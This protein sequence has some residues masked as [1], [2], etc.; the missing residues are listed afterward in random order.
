MC[1]KNQGDLGREPGE[2]GREVQCLSKS[3][4]RVKA[5][6]T[7]LT[8]EMLDAVTRPVPWPKAGTWLLIHK[9]T[10]PPGAAL[11]QRLET[12]FSSDPCNADFHKMPWATSIP[13]RTGPQPSR[14]MSSSLSAAQIC[15]GEKGQVLALLSHPTVTVTSAAICPRCGA[16]PT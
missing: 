16:A 12:V 6:V 7:G 1:R 11:K 8:Q 15:L 13:V 10:A 14:Q 5:G 4:A 2:E 3:H 9:I